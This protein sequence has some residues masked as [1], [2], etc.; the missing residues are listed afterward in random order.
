MKFSYSPSLPQLALAVT[1]ALVLGC[2]A[3]SS[4]NQTETAAE[5]TQE[6]VLPPVDNTISEAESADGWKLLFDGKTTKGW[7][8]YRQDTIGKSWI[9]EDG[10]LTLDA[11]KQEDWHWRAP[12]GGDIVSD[13]QYGNFELQLEWKISACGNSGIIFLVVEDEKYPDIWRTGPEMQI[14]D[15]VCHPDRVFPTHRAGSLYDLIQAQPETVK[16]AGEWNQARIVLNQGHLEYWLNGT[17]VVETQ[18]GTPAWD[19]MVAKSKFGNKTHT[20][21]SPD[22]GKAPRG[23]IALQDHKDS[24]VSFRNIKIREL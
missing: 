16:P 23:H 14:L 10:A 15:N 1:F 6:E 7:H 24:K 9:I 3:C 20:D 18:L 12:H 5:A 2:G 4:N 19:E 11:T 13:Q 22:Y 8:N 17:Q 21:Y